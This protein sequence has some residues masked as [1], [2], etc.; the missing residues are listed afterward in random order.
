MNEPPARDAWRDVV[1]ALRPW[2]WVKNVVVLLPLFFARRYGEPDAVVRALI[3]A[4]AFCPLASAIYLWN[5]VKDRAFDRAHPARRE[6]PIAAGRV[7]PRRAVW[8][9]VVLAA[10]G[11]LGLLVIAALSPASHRSFPSPWPLG[12]GALYLAL[13]I[14]YVL[15]LKPWP[16]LGALAIAIGFLLRVMAGGA[17]VPVEVSHWLAVCVPL[18]GLCVALAKRAGDARFAGGRARSDGL[19]RAAIVAGIVFVVVYAAYTVAPRTVAEFGSR[20]LALSILPLAA[21]VARLLARMRRGDPVADPAALFLRDPLLL[22]ALAL[23]AAAVLPVLAAS[24]SR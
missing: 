10:L 24:G 18:G 22:A 7:A 14:G 2:Q 4:L 9:G 8:L 19:E 3:A 16:L 1:L 6:R 11:L 23:Y 21:G 20:G 5:D 17:A 13:Q 15:A 12:Y